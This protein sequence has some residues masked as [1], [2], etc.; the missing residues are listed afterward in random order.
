MRRVTGLGGVFFRCEDPQKMRE[1]YKTHLGI[2]SNQYGG[3][4]EWRSLEDPEKICVT[5]WNPF[6]QSTEYF[7]PSEKQFMFNYRVDD[8]AS[9]LE[10]LRKEGVTV[11]D[12]IQEY[13]FGKFGWIMDPEGNKIELWEPIDKK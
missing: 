10:E 6:P 9:L 3:Q 1:W 2:D 5:A 13:D 12:T 8:L 11:V 4:F 7:K